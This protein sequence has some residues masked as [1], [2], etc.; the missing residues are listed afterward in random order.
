MSTQPSTKR[1]PRMLA[2]RKSEEVYTILRKRI[3]LSDIHDNQTITE[4]EIAAATGCSQST[5]REAL[6]R[7]Q[8]EGLVVRKAYRGSV[9]S[10]ISINEAQA[11]LKLRA[12]LESEALVHSLPLVDDSHF[13]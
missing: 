6:L 5:V 2:S 8:E 12:Q 3:V 9:V 13:E 10:P 11:F 4:M 1:S 7:L